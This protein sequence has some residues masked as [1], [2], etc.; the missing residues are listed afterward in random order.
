M[1]D[2]VIKSAL[3]DFENDS[4]IDAKEKLKGEISKARDEFLKQKLGLEKDITPLPVPAKE[5]PIVDKPKKRPSLT[6]K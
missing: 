2:N 6:G 4:F 1:D 3:D 5:E